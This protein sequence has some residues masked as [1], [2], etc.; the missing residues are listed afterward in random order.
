MHKCPHA[1]LLYQEAVS[2]RN[3]PSPLHYIAIDEDSHIGA[4]AVAAGAARGPGVQAARDV[5]DV[6]A[7][8]LLRL[9]L[10]VACGGKRHGRCDQSSTPLQ[11]P[12]M[13][14]DA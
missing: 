5:R 13:F 6:V 14:L 2:C 1:R 9:L 11:H 10:V 8:R 7:E 4:G 12:A 3:P